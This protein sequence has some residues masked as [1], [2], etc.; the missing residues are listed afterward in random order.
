M[1][2]YTFTCSTNR[3]TW[4]NGQIPETEVWVKVGG[5][6]G[7]D[8][9]KMIFQLCNVISPNSV[10]NTCVVTMFEGRDTTANVH[11]ALDRYKPQFEHLRATQWRY[12]YLHTCILYI[13]FTCTHMHIVHCTGKR[14][15][16]FMSGDFE[17]LSWMYG[18]TGAQGTCTCI[19]TQRGQC[20]EV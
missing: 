18:I 20:I 4:H 6:K 1:Y 9:V 7:A 16:L 15:Q 8:T 11:V 12:I 13:V 5:N 2:I 14:I 3:L 17:F 10:Q 19:Y